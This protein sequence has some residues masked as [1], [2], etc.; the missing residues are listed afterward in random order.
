MPLQFSPQSLIAVALAVVALAASLYIWHVRATYGSIPLLLL[1]LV[2]AQ[3]SLCYGLEVASVDAATK[4][5]WAKAQWFGVTLAPV[6]WLATAA[7]GTSDW[8]LILGGRRW[9]IWLLIPALIMILVVTNDLHNLVWSDP[10][11]ASSGVAWPLH[12]E[13]SNHPAFPPKSSVA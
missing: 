5:I 4:L 3:W 10:A 8:P 13:R 11:L 1:T 6:L 7:R 12:L 9:L 2:A